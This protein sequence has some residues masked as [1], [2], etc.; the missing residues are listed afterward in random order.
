LKE[1]SWH[2]HF[3]DIIYNI[4]M[5]RGGTGIRKSNIH[6]L[7]CATTHITVSALLLG[8]QSREADEMNSYA[9]L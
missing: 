3:N 2:W 6:F 4:N 5:E 8:F 7:L 1:I 9:A